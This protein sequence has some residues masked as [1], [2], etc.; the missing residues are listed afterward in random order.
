[1]RPEVHLC[2]KDFRRGR[3]DSQ[4]LAELQLNHQR[5]FMQCWEGYED[6]STITGYTTHSNSKTAAP[7]WI[8]CAL[9]RSTKDTIC[10]GRQ[11]STLVV[12]RHR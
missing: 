11:P 12:R 6:L 2:L 3:G 4:L 5:L 10:L 7:I 1:M 9:R 8:V